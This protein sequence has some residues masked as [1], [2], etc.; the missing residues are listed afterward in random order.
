MNEIPIWWL[1]V[2]AIFYVA[3]IAMFVGLLVLAMTL[4]RVVEKLQP[5]I[6]GVATKVEAVT[7]TVNGLT[8]K[9]EGITTKVDGIANTVRGVADSAKG[10]ADTAKRT[11]ENVGSRTNEL[12]S[13]LTNRAEETLAPAMVLRA[14]GGLDHLGRQRV[15]RALLESVKDGDDARWHGRAPSYTWVAW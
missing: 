9:V 3:G 13:N 15:G 10:V 11:V 8:Q 6:A 4:K 2:S 7:E 1:I 12:M 14:T 5:S